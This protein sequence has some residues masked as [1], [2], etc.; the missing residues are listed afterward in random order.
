MVFLL[1]LI[2]IGYEFGYFNKEYYFIDCPID[3][4]VAV[5]KIYGEIITYG[6]GLVDPD[7]PEIIEDDITSSEIIDEVD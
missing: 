4:N 6:V 1:A 7:D 3:S 2:I 5:I